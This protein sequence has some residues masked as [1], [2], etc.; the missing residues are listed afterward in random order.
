MNFSE[1]QKKFRERIISKLKEGLLNNSS[2]YAFW[3]EGADATG[4]IDKYSDIDIW[5]DVKDGQEDRIFK[6]IKLILLKLAEIDVELE[7]GHPHPKIRQK[8]FHLKGTSDFLIIDVCLQ[9][10]SRVF[11]YTKEYA[12]EKVKI[13]FDKCKVVK[14]RKLDKDKFNREIIERTKYLQ[15]IFSFY[16][17]WIKKELKRKNF[18]GAFNY[19]H[20]KILQPLV[21]LFRIKYQPTKK[22][23]YLK[24][25]K[26][27]LP[28]N[29]VL[30]L[31]NL[32][33]IKSLSDIEKNVKIANNLFYKILKT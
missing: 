33:K 14:F 29:I 21:E 32:Y 18:L 6:E 4:K 7:V 3:L 13:I 8:F 23:Y 9:S 1:Y 10:H 12:G 25:I 26:I 27:D 15:K 28:K 5:L 17:I 2:I 16:Q 24:D 20:L 19:Y 30:K 22:D 11:W 31:D